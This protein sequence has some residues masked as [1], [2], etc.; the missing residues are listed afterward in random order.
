MNGM[1]FI[2]RHAKKSYPIA[3]LAVILAGVFLRTY[4]FHDWLQFKGDAFRDANLVSHI[5]ADGAESL[6]LLGPRA[7]GT[8]LRLGPAFYYF[9]YLSTAVFR[10]I[11][12]PVLAYPDLLF[13][14]LAMPMLFLFAR[15]YFSRMWSLASVAMLAVSFLAI[16]YGRFAWN[17]NSAPFFTILFS[18][19]VLRVS[20]ADT[21]YRPLFASMAGLSLAIVSQLHFSAFLG[22]P[23]VLAAFIIWNR[24]DVKSAWGYGVVLPFILSVLIVYLPVFANEILKHGENSRQFFLAISAKSS[25]G[26]LLPNIRQDL[27]MFAKYFLRMSLGVVESGRALVVVGGI[28]CGA[29]YLSNAFLLRGERDAS[30]RRFLQWTLV[31]VSTY[32]L[33][34]VPLAFKIDRPRF[35]LPLLA[36]PYL[37]IGYMALFLRKKVSYRPA[38][39]AFVFLL[40]GAVIF[41]NIRSTFGW[42]S[43]LGR[44]QITADSG[45]KNIKGKN[46]LFTWSHFERMAKVMEEACDDGEPIFFFLSKNIAEYDHSVEYA[47]KTRNPGLA[48]FPEKGYDATGPGGCYYYV[49]LPGGSPLP[50]MAGETIGVPTD[51]GGALVF[52]WRHFS[53]SGVVTDDRIK[54]VDIGDGEG[55]VPQKMTKNSRLY[56]GDVFYAIG[57]K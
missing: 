33:L 55:F 27:F 34:Y 5:Y 2:R 35:F 22:L 26:G 44:S 46:V 14:V 6:P 53:S 10:S 29:G 52:H 37:H 4:H 47:L 25:K 12:A 42:F 49:S 24:K 11:D 51:V 16:E 7:G 56:W 23:I 21:K 13:S 17:P 48:I 32:I 31:M 19:A 43:E 54:A 57:K 40:V 9:Q 3:V 15:M 30:K 39:D 41:G 45:G 38:V 20:D 36:I 1:E 18:Y 8:M 28:L 50:S